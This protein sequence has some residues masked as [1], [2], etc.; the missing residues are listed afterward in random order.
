MMACDSSGE[1]RLVDHA[2]RVPLTYTL[3]AVKR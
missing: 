2:E 1:Y 3:Q